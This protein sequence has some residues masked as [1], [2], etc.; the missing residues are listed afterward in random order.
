M[1]SCVA[2]P[3]QAQWRASNSRM[4]SAS[5]TTTLIFIQRWQGVL[6]A[7]ELELDSSMP[8]NW[9]GFNTETSICN[10]PI[11]NDPESAARRR[12]AQEQRR[13]NAN[14]LEEPIPEADIVAHEK[15]SVVGL[16]FI[17]LCALIDPTAQQSRSCLGVILPAKVVMVTGDHPTAQAIAKEVISSGRRSCDGSR[18]RGDQHAKV[19]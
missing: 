8:A 13:S 9:A 17:G 5:V 2:A 11:G 16:T 1:S 15:N 12:D 10:F 18:S 19:R 7:A 6:A 3:C 14:G 4:S